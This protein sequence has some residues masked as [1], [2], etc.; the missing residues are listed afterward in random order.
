M[1]KKLFFAVMVCG[2]SLAMTACGGEEEKENGTAAAIQQEEADTEEADEEGAKEEVTEESGTETEEASASAVT[3]T[4]YDDID[5][6]YQFDLEGKHYKLPCTIDE[7]IQNECIIDEDYLQ[8]TIPAQHSMG[9]IKTH[10][11]ADEN[12]YVYLEVLNDTDQDMTV[13]ECQKV[14]GIT[15]YDDSEVSF[16]LNSGLKFVYDEAFFADLKKTYGTD[17]TIYEEDDYGATWCF[18]HALPKEDDSFVISS[19]LQPGTDRMNLD[20]NS[21]E[22]Q[23]I[24]RK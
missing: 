6:I 16:V 5:E 14:V 9:M 1:R 18:Y 22:L 19:S 13:Q 24:G 23:Y 20:N 12:K 2:I 7:F 8:E 3:V 10:P 17:E 4:S 11:A 15:V 21:F